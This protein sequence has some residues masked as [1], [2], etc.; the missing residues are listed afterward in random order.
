MTTK[1]LVVGGG[2][3]EHAIVSALSRAGADIYVA[4]KNKNPGIARACRSY[5]L[6]NETDVSKVTDFALRSGVELAIIGPEAPLEAGIADSLE[7]HGI[8]CVGPTKAA[9]RVET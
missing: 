6:L 4:M 1:V 8:G 2:G 5:E 7:A 9:A 3:R